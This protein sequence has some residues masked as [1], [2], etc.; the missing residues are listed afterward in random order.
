MYIYVYDMYIYIY[1]HVCVCCGQVTWDGWGIVIHS[2]MGII[3]P[4]AGDPRLKWAMNR[5]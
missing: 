2:I 1:I 4:A 3:V 5:R